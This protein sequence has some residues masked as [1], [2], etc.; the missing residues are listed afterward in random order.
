MHSLHNVGFR[1]SASCSAGILPAVLIFCPRHPD[2]AGRLTV[3]LV[4]WVSAS[5]AEIRR[6]DAGAT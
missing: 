3:P 4:N 2:F 6:Q 5:A 1:R